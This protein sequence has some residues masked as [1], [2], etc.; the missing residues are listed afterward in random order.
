MTVTVKVTDPGVELDFAHLWE[1]VL[2]ELVTRT[3][4]RTPVRTG[5]LR[6]SIQV[7]TVSDDGGEYG[8]DVEYAGY[9]ENGTIYMEPVGMFR[10]TLL[11]LPEIIEKHKQEL[12]R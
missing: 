4:D 5:R 8:S 2:D 6:D 7:S 1:V 3:Q 12:T 11:E 9:V 10:T